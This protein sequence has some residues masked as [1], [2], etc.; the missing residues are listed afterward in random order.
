M[1]NCV[2]Y[3]EKRTEYIL[4]LTGPNPTPRMMKDVRFQ[5]STNVSLNLS[6]KWYVKFIRKEGNVTVPRGK[7]RI[8]TIRNDVTTMYENIF[9]YMYRVILLF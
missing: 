6:T 7:V 8:L 9:Q 1:G 2:I 5:N 4:H 3:Y